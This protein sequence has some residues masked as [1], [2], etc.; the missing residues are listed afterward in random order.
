M[1]TKMELTTKEMLEKFKEVADELSKLNGQVW[2]FREVNNHDWSCLAELLLSGSKAHI[3]LSY[4][5]RTKK[6]SMS[7]GFSIIVENRHETL[8]GE[9]TCIGASPHKS[10][11]QL[12]S[13]INRR[14]LPFYLPEF[15]K[16]YQS[17][18]EWEVSRKERLQMLNHYA[19]IIGVEPKLAHDSDRI[20]GYRKVKEVMVCSRGVDLK[21]SV[22]HEQA[23][24][25]LQLICKP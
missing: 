7:G 11:A 16:A 22:S 12:A 24:Q 15:E 1:V 13:D 5:T 8:Y 23:E 14:L 6:L 20:Y 2:Q 25:I 4:H 10:P 3:N 9:R 17:H 19:N 18:C 21:L